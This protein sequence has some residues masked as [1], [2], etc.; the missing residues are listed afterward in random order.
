MPRF[1]AETVEKL[2]NMRRRA[3]SARRMAN[4]FGARNP[5]AA[6]YWH[7]TASMID[8]MADYVESVAFPM[9]PVQIAGVWLPDGGRGV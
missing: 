4:D 7:G 9:P 3:D 2:H 6:A 8:R 1:N 5:G